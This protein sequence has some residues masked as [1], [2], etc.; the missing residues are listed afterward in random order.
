MN[1]NRKTLTLTVP[2]EWLPEDPGPD[3]S[4]VPTLNRDLTTTEDGRQYF[5][6]E[7]LQYALRQMLN[8]SGVTPERGV[9]I[10]E[11]EMTATIT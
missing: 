4:K 1:I 8:R 10:Q 9:W 5:F 3:L 7:M 2:V 11:E 6:A